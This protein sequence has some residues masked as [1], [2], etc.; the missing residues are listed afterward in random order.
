MFAPGLLEIE[1]KT[2]IE[3]ERERERGYEEQK[4]KKKTSSNN[5][6]GEEWAEMQGDQEREFLYRNGIVF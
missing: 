6:M 3:R 5:F 2:K 4:G 1:T